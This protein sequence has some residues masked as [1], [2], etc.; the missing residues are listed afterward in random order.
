MIPQVI[1][2]GLHSRQGWGPSAFHGDRALTPFQAGRI[3]VQLGVGRGDIARI[4]AELDV[5]WRTVMW[6]RIRNCT[7]YGDR[8]RV[9]LVGGCEYGFWRVE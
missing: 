7:E 6:T 2:G 8:V 4:C 1:D 3:A 5:A 9:I